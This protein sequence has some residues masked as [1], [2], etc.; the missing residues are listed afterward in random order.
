M[1]TQKNLLQEIHKSSR[2]TFSIFRLL[3]SLAWNLV[4]E[5]L[6]GGSHSILCSVLVHGKVLVSHL[7]FFYFSVSSCHKTE[8]A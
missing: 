2:G 6:N 7:T 1:K 3:I 4:S 8:E 5:S